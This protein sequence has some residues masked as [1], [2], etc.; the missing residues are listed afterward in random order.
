[1]ST[2][3]FSN[4]V[5]LQHEF[6][7]A[8]NF[9]YFKKQCTERDIPLLFTEVVVPTLNRVATQNLFPV[10]NNFNFFRFNS[11]KCYHKM[12]QKYEDILNDNTLIQDT[13]F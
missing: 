11:D 7:I 1:M 8:N 10:K 5:F 13:S 6:D 4:L 3:A 2:Y 12:M 9:G